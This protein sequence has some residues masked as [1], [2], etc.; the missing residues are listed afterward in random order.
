MAVYKGKLGNETLW[1]SWREG[2]LQPGI[3]SP[4]MLLIARVRDEAH[5]FAG[6]YMKKRKQASMF[7][8]AL[9][10]IPGI[11]PAKRVALLKH[12]GG[13]EGVKAASREHLAAVP[14]ISPGLAER[15]FH[16]LHQ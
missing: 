1:P 14:G 13:I 10:A 2:S 9:D 7:T 12:F 4:A 16:S 5:R 11:G 3:H 6:Q 15:I 8:S